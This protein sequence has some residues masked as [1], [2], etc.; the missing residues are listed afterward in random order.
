ML[1]TE[2]AAL[3]LQILGVV[4][5]LSGSIEHRTEQ[6]ESAGIFEQ[7][8]DVHGQYVAR[9]DSESDRLEAFK[10]ALFIQWFSV[11]EP[12]FCTG[13]CDVSADTSL[14]VIRQLDA[15]IQTALV[16]QES[17]LLWMLAWYFNIADWAFTSANSTTQDWLTANSSRPLP[18]PPPSQTA[19]EGRGQLSE[20]WISILYRQ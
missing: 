5:S 4:G 20:Y 16:S 9:F 14:V 6:L 7:Y 15:F 10:R 2:L 11:I 17:E 1:L 3:E 12:P 13:I 19:I 8:A 18:S